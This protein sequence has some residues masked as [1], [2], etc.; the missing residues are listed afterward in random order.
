[1]VKR[2]CF[3]TNLWARAFQTSKVSLTFV[4]HEPFVG[5]KTQT[6]CNL[7]DDVIINSSMTEHVADLWL[8]SSAGQHF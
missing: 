4:G 5:L 6:L 7:G 2:T 1:M 8:K 3:I